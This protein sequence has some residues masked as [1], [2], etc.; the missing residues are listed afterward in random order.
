MGLKIYF[1]TVSVSIVGALAFTAI[2]TVFVLPETLLLVAVM[3]ISVVNVVLAYFVDFMSN[4]F[5]LRVTVNLSEL[6]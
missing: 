4:V 1:E 5:P 3:V 2:F 6:V